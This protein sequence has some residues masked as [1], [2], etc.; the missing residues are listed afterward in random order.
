MRLL[1]AGRSNKEIAAQLSISAKT[2]E[3][4]VSRLMKRFGASSRIDAVVKGLFD[5]D[6]RP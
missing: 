2:V 6:L 3:F 5:P 1:T 4:H